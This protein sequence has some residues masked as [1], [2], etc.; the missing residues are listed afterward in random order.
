MGSGKGQARRT[1]RIAPQEETDEGVAIL[2]VDGT[3]EWRLDGRASRLSRRDG[4][5][6][7]RE[8]GMKEWWL[9]G[10]RYREHDLPTIEYLD[11]TQ[12]WCV[13]GDENGSLVYHRYDGPAIIRS[14]GDQEWYLNGVRHREDGPAVETRGGHKSWLQN[15]HLHREVGPAVEYEDGKREWYQKVKQHREDGPAVVNIDGSE[16]WWI[17]GHEATE[18]EVR[19]IVRFKLLEKSV[20]DFPERNTF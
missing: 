19:K 7:I 2:C 1:Q 5:A 20:L 14:S 17:A 13:G 18:E 3:R 10:V 15:G 8:D 16:E 12:A 6:V 9:M 11:G 4:P